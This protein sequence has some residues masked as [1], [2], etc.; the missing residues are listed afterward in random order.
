MS[1]WIYSQRIY[2]YL[3]PVLYIDDLFEHLV[4]LLLEETIF[5]MLLPEKGPRQWVC[6]GHPMKIGVVSY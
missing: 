6:L 4:P 2:I 3:F 5:T 1:A